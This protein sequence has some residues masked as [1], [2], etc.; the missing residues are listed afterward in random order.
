MCDAVRLDQGD[1]RGVLAAPLVEH[2]NGTRVSFPC[3]AGTSR[4][5]F[6]KTATSA[7]ADLASSTIAG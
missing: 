2:M 1:G 4:F 5:F 3:F 7:A 6:V